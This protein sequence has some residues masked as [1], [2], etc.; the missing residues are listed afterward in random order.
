MSSTCSSG[1]A[2]C[3][4]FRSTRS[5]LLTRMVRCLAKAVNSASLKAPSHSAF[6]SRRMRLSDCSKALRQC[7][8]VATGAHSHARS[9]CRWRRITAVPVMDT[10][11]SMQSSSSNVASSHLGDSRTCRA[12]SYLDSAAWVVHVR[13][14]CH[15]R[16]L[17]GS[18]SSANAE[19]TLGRSSATRIARVVTSY[20][21]LRRSWL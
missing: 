9:G 8:H 16:R 18:T 15:S 4:T 13:A 6:S 10:R 1:C 3:T 2:L 21:A 19:R 11:A 5:S 20:Q 12:T 17:R 7:P 14:S